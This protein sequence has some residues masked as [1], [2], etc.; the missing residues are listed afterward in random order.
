M[1]WKYFYFWIKW[2]KPA[3]LSSTPKYIILIG[4]RQLQFGVASVRFTAICDGYFLTRRNP[5]ATLYFK[6]WRKFLKI[7]VSCKNSSFLIPFHSRVY[8]FQFCARG[9]SPSLSLSLAR[10]RA[11]FSNFNLSTPKNRFRYQPLRRPMIL[12]HS[13][14]IT[15]ARDITTEKEKERESWKKRTRQESSENC[16]RRLQMKK[17]DKYLACFQPLPCFFFSHTRSLPSSGNR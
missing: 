12:L 6:L 13:F 11:L 1:V 3:L 15:R 4:Q 14:N 7:E 2:K 16:Q 8:L 9:F 10:S 17:D 5:R